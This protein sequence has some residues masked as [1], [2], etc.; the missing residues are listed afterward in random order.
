[1]ARRYGKDR[2]YSPFAISRLARA[3]T[4]ILRARE[5][6]GQVGPTLSSSEAVR[7]WIRGA[8]EMSS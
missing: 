4:I 2:R 7:K 1:M 6:V 5:E 3:L 8:E